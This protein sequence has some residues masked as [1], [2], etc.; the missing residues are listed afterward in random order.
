MLG[1]RGLD[2]DVAFSR[3]EEVDRTTLAPRFFGRDITLGDLQTV[4]A[5]GR[6]HGALPFFRNFYGDF[7]SYRAT[8][9]R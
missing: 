5:F 3:G 7:A 8:L 1:L 4:V 6:V 9:T 2:F